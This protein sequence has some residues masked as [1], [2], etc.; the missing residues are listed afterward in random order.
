MTESRSGS[1]TEGERK[2]ESG[3][4]SA[5]LAT[6]HTVAATSL[7]WLHGQHQ[8]GRGALPPDAGIEPA[9]P[10]GAYK[11]L[12]EYALAASLVL[13]ERVAG[14]AETRLARELLE[15]GWQQLRC[16]DL[17]FDRQLRYQ[18][19]TDPLETYAHF[20]RGGYRHR[21]L[22][23]LLAELGEL[24]SSHAVEMYPNRRLAVAN[25]RRVAGLDHRPDWGALADATWLG[26]RPEPWAIDWKTAYDMTHTVFHLTDWGARPEGLPEPIASYLHDW[27]PVWLDVWSEAG[28]WDLVGELLIVDA[29]LARPVGDAR[30]W[31]RLAQ[32]Q[33]P[34]G[35]LPRD[36]DPVDDSDPDATFKNH[37]HTAVVAVVAGTLTLARALGTGRA[38]TA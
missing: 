27:L 9:D 15:R 12:G 3:S 4:K 14:A 2:T 29:C 36:S 6:A 37:E 34:D 8:L 16:G 22:D 10:D 23:Q 13:R 24:R 17:L 5:T 18:L 31:E 33:R 25:A 35:L 20:V 7:A 21:A 1:K 28:L 19:L 32:A 11:P 26:A 30:A 38:A